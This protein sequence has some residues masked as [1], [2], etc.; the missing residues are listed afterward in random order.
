MK[1]ET[2]ACKN[3][4]TKVLTTMYNRHYD[5]HCSR[6]YKIELN[7]MLISSPSLL[8]FRCFFQIHRIIC[9]L[10][11]RASY[12]ISLCIF[13]IH[14]HIR[15][16]FFLSGCRLLL[17]AAAERLKCGDEIEWKR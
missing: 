3:R 16:M 7:F 2:N 15:E 14:F 5:C 13:M 10:H 6:E 12:V 4:P 17:T 8:F 11:V 1:H 9:S